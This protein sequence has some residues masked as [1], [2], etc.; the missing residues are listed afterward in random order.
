MT[1]TILALDLGTTTGWALR[2]SDGHI[3]SGSELPAAALRRRRNALP[4]LQTLAH[5]D[6]AILRRHRLPALRRGAPPRLDR[7]GPRLRRVPAT[8]TAWCEHH[9]I[10][11]QGVP[12]GTIKKH[13][14]GKG[15]AGKEMSSLPSRAGTRRSTTTKPMPWR[16]CTGPSSSTTTGREV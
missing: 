10:P 4:A 5:R 9:Q 13:A 12:V 7:R 6:Q 8:L 11:Y 3:T 14:T 2:G 1:T 16:C 15:N